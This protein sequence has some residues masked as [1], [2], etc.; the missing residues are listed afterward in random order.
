MVILFIAALTVA[1]VGI[2][3]FSTK[4]RKKK[5]RERMQLDILAM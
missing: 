4:R 5:Q 2:V 1:A 3:V